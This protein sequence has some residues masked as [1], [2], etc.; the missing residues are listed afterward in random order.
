MLIPFGGHALT[1]AIDD[2]LRESCGLSTYL[3]IKLVINNIITLAVCNHNTVPIL[4]YSS[5]E[6][7]L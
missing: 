1:A 5:S 3:D 2:I 4:A 6:H 7:H